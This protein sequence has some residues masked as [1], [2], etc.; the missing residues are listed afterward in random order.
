MF[1]NRDKKVHLKITAD[2]AICN[3]P[4]KDFYRQHKTKSEPVNFQ[5]VS[6]VTM[7]NLL[8]TCATETATPW[9]PV[10][11]AIEASSANTYLDWGSH[12]M[13]EQS[14]DFAVPTVVSL[15]V[16]ESVI[17][18]D[19]DLFGLWKEAEVKERQRVKARNQTCVV[20]PAIEHEPYCRPSSSQ[21]CREVSIVWLL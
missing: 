18:R 4:K 5:C 7:N 9:S 15:C 17:Q 20:L 2:A 1:A 13:C 10:V 6:G 21:H 19:T 16:W 11:G 14:S 3:N 12:S 8:G